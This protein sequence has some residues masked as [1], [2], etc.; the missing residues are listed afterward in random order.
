MSEP[1]LSE[2]L[3]QCIASGVAINDELMIYHRDGEWHAEMG[4]PSA[5]C[6]NLGES[7]GEFSSGGYPCMNLFE[8]PEQ[9][10]A[11]LLANLKNGKKSDER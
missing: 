1:T 2:L 5:H 11:A 3:A 9:A 7:S 10:V 8:T 4:N 6:V